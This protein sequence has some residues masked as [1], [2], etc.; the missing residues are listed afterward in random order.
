[1]DIDHHLRLPHDTDYSNLSCHHLLLSSFLPN[2]LLCKVSGGARTANKPIRHR[3][4]RH[5]AY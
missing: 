2:V 3:M 5:R 1:M 4:I